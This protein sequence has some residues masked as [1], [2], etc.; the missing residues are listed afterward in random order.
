MAGVLYSDRTDNFSETPEMAQSLV[1]DV[2]DMYEDKGTKAFPMITVDPEFRGMELY[3]FVIRDNDGIIVAD[4]YKKSLVGKNMDTITDING[5]NIGK[6]IHYSATEDGTWVE[7]LS[8]NPVT[9]EVLPKSTWLV[10]YDG[11]I[12]GSGIYLP[13]N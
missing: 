11:Y 3:V 4:G 10:K 6:M 8:E 7:Y 2:I 5:K 12:F 1:Y 9:K 13:T